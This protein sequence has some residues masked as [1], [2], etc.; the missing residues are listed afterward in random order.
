MRV[1]TTVVCGSLAYDNIMLF[2]GRFG[3]QILPDKVHI[4]NVA[5]EVPE[6][7]REYDGPTD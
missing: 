5:F 7:R 6:M 2:R 1:G 3:E 4:L